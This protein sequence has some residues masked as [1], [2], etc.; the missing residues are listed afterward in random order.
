[1]AWRSER[2]RN[3][4]TT[5]CLVWTKL[6]ATTKEFASG[7]KCF[8]PAEPVL[9]Q[10]GPPAEP[11]WCKPPVQQPSLRHRQ[12]GTKE[13]P[14]HTLTMPR[15]DLELQ[16]DQ[17]SAVLPMIQRKYPNIEETFAISLVLCG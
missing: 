1:M 4:L 8:K 9:T 16:H 3:T 7:S 13:Q 14:N 6:F 12:L 17:A 10:T 2:G 15:S 5:G 11:S